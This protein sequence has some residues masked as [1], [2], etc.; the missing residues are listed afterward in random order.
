MFIAHRFA[1]KDLLKA[2]SN[3]F[4]LDFAAPKRE[5]LKEEHANGGKMPFC[6]SQQSP[7]REL[8][9]VANGFSERIYSRKAQYHWGEQII[10]HKSLY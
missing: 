1:V 2:G 6:E 4:V 5:A 9:S 7:G 3:D 8:T 10:G